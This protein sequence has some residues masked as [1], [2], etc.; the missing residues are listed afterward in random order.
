MLELLKNKQGTCKKLPKLH[1]SNVM[2]IEKNQ[3]NVRKEKIL[4]V[5]RKKNYKNIIKNLINISIMQVSFL[6]IL[7]ISFRKSIK[8]S[9]T[10]IAKILDRN[11]GM[12]NV[13]NCQVTSIREMSTK[14]CNFFPKFCKIFLER[15][16]WTLDV[17][18]FRTIM[19]NIAK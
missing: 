9:A 15:F 4:K 14:L 1:K 13:L 19:V 7:K 16:V 6:Y 12:G 2:A 18:K 11:E 5:K 17:G 3:P 8:I 10:T